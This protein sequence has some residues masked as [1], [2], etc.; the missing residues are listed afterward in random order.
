LPGGVINPAPRIQPA[1]ALF[2]DGKPVA[3]IC[4]GPWIETGAPRADGM[5]SLLGIW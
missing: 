4:H 5:K 1:A 3:A 2:E